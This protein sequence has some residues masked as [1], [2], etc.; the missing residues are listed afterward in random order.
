[1]KSQQ[2]SN[3][4]FEK[5][6]KQ[7]HKEEL[8]KIK[9]LHKLEL[10]PKI[11]NLKFYDGGRISKCPPPIG[12]SHRNY[13]KRLLDIKEEE[14]SLVYKSIED[15]RTIY[16]H[17]QTDYLNSLLTKVQRNNKLAEDRM[18][19]IASHSSVNYQYWAKMDLWTIHES[20]TL[21]L[22]KDPKVVGSKSVSVNY[23]G[24]TRKS[25]FQI[26]YEEIL[27]IA[28]TSINTL[29]LKLNN[30]PDMFI[31]WA[32]SKNIIVPINMRDNVVEIS[33]S[34]N[35]EELYND[36]KEHLECNT[37]DGTT[38]KNIDTNIQSQRENIL[39]GWL[40]GKGYNFDS[41][42]K[43]SKAVLWD[44]LNKA[45]NNLFP[46]T[47]ESTRKGFFSKQSLCKFKTGRPTNP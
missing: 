47:S 39:R 19:W 18:P 27:T 43:I 20:I 3:K 10:I 42:I 4:E 44:E 37:L 15:V 31:K 29:K 12:E 5:R 9:M 23:Y 34:P 8:E 26:E 13:D 24:T 25:N 16:F 17:L 46:P 11:I 30:A 36:I 35:Y 21:L 45:S 38:L 32:D 6:V 14:K 33:N 1:M 41:T 40:V 28:Q 22:E 2:V 7:H